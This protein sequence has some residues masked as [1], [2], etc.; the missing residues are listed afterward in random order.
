MKTLSSTL[1]SHSHHASWI[2]PVWVPTPCTLSYPSPVFVQ[3]SKSNSN[4]FWV[5]AGCRGSEGCGRMSRLGF[6]VGILYTDRGSDDEVGGGL[7]STKEDDRWRFRI[8][9]EDVISSKHKRKR[10]KTHITAQNKE[11]LMD[12]LRVRNEVKEESY[13]SFF[14]S[15]QSCNFVSSPRKHLNYHYLSLSSQPCNFVSSPRHQVSKYCFE[16]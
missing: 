6:C 13:P 4:L 11:T 7:T 12:L 5:E 10:Y 8:G 15:H 9:S 1:S 16:K 2:S 14:S 3:L